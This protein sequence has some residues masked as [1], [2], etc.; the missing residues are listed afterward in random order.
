MDF[1]IFTQIGIAILILV[2]TAI[3][4][5]LTKNKYLS[6]KT[7]NQID[8][9]FDFTYSLAKQINLV[10]QPYAKEMLEITNDTL[11]YF[12][13]V[14]DIEADELKREALIVALEVCKKR[15]LDV[16]EERKEILKAII[17]VGIEQIIKIK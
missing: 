8:L 2:A 12:K 1:T 6:K 3:F 13:K 10:K 11:N 17:N 14:D 4:Y 5:F 15:N 16:D 9:C 7:L